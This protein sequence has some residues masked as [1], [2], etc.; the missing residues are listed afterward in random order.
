MTR[1]EPRRAARVGSSSYFF[2][3][4]IFELRLAPRVFSKD[5][6]VAHRFSPTFLASESDPS[7]NQSRIRPAGAPNPL[8]P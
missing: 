7:K 3:L 5:F 2:D 4:S 8:T 6:G 1:I